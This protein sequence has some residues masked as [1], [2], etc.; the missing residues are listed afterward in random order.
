MSYQSYP[1][2]GGGGYPP[3]Y[4]TNDGN[5]ALA[6]ISGIL[7][8]GIAGMLGFATIDLLGDIPSEVELP[9]GWIAMFILNFLVVALG[10]LGAILV[11]ARQFAGAFVLLAA[12]F[13]AV[14]AVLIDGAMAE[15]LVGFMFGALPEITATSEYGA[16]LEA[17]FEFGNEQAVLFAISLF[18]GAL[19]LI[20]AA[21]PPSTKYLRGSRGGYAGY[22]QGW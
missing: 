3:A 1:Q 15:G 6:I 2:Q 4:P 17:I 11:F 22:Q 16:Y 12:G 9:G 10:L 13:M 19:L 21:L 20:I 18:A 7:G 8:L 5:P 14:L